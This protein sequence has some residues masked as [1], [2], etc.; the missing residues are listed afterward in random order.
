MPRASAWW[1][2]AGAAALLAAFTGAIIVS[3]ARGRSPDCH[4]FGPLHP[5]RTGW[6]TLVRNAA[7]AG[8]AVLIVWQGRGGAGS[9]VM[10]AGIDALSRLH[11][12]DVPVA[13]L[14]AAL[15]LLAAFALWALVHLLRQNGRLMLRLDEIESRLADARLGA[16]AEAASIRPPAGAGASA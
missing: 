5:S 13:G 14:A 11:P 6:R 15:L 3:L 1:G 4:C 2:A 16:S 8:V 10:E 12:A 7:L 9:G